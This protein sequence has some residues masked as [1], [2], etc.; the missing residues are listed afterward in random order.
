MTFKTRTGSKE[1]RKLFPKIDKITDRD[2]RMSYKGGWTYLNPIYADKIVG[3]GQVYDVNSMYPWAMRNCILPYGEPMYFFGTP[4]PPPLYQLFVVQLTAAFQLKPNH[5]PSIQI[6]HTMFFSDNEYIVSSP[7][8]MQLTLTNVDLELFFENYDVEDV[9]YIGGYYFKA[10]HG[11]FT[12]YIDYWYH[13]KEES[14]RTGNKGMKQIAKLMLNSLYGKFGMKLDG[15][16]KI[17]YYDKENDLVRYK[18]SE[19]EDR[20]GVYIPVA[21]FITSYCRDKIIRSA[22]SIYDRFVYADT[23][24]IHLLGTN[25]VSEIEIDNYRLGAFKLESEFIR[26]RFVRQKTYYEISPDEEMELKCAGM[27]RNMKNTVEEKDFYYGA[28]F[29]IGPDSKFSPKLSPKTVPG[30]VILREM[31]FKIH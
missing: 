12:D 17:P 8:P 7:F 9:K 14:D 4:K 27:P 5:Y 16:S 10:Q 15:R 2:I 13:I 1:F 11:M 31:P 30:G 26:A 28:E 3:A 24:S 21:T 6:K 22:N 23:D 19:L 20:E 18:L 25:P 29:P